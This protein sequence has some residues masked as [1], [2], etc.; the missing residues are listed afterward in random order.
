MNR[1]D[2]SAFGKPHQLY[3]CFI[4][5]INGIHKRL[6]PDSHDLIYKVVGDMQVVVSILNGQLSISV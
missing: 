3:Y 4:S 1:N 6:F 5:T 2:V